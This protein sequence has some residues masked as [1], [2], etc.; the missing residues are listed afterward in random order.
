MMTN[1]PGNSMGRSRKGRAF[2]LL[3][4][5]LAISI[6]VVLMVMMGS[7]TSHVGKIWNT[8]NAQNQ[9]R[10]VAR[11][12]VQFMASE[13]QTAT[14]P[15]PDTSG[16]GVSGTQN[17]QFAVN[18][19]SVGI[20]STC[21]N[22]HAIFFQAPV[23]KNTTQGVVAA[24][25]YFV[26]WDTTT[27]PRKPTAYLSR[28]YAD[29]SKASDYLV[30]T[31]STWASNAL[32][33]AS[34]IP[35]TYTGWIA[36]NVIALW[37]RCLDTKG[38]PITLNASGRAFD[39]SSVFAFDSA[40]GYTDPSTSVVHRAPAFPPCVEITV[41]VVDSDAAQ[42]IKTAPTIPLPSDP[43]DLIKGKSTPGSIL[44]FVDQLP[45]KVKSGA[46][47]FTTTVYLPSGTN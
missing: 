9:R 15:V 27:N 32:S 8:V 14:L 19:S 28:Y 24:V 39:S 43:A 4:V 41:V 46:E 16:T 47:I 33:V 34:T 22:S 25:G 37:I 44:N 29:P 1:R 17:L 7:M 31:T 36:D 18:L 40:Q 35:P 23:A 5:M 2:T 45:A 20:P 12:L 10:T 6:L 26:Q 13:I 30:Y 42:R 21:M 11:A 3:E 38:V